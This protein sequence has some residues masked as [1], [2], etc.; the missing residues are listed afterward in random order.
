MPRFC[1]HK[2]L[3]YHFNSQLGFFHLAWPF[4][5]REIGGFLLSSLRSLGSSS[6]SSTP[7]S[8]LAVGPFYYC[9]K[10][11]TKREK[12]HLKP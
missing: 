10:N 6:F 9:E 3:H 1:L 7:T 8:N 2:N 11:E 4:E 12:Y 5:S